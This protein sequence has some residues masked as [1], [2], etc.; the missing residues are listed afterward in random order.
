MSRKEIQDLADKIAT[1]NVEMKDGDLSDHEASTHL[2]WA[3]RK[4]DDL[5]DKLV[6]LT[7]GEACAQYTDPVL[8]DD[9]S[10]LTGKVSSGLTY[11]E[12]C[13]RVGS[14]AFGN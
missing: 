5:V 9:Y 6:V 12:L 10:A 1:L 11:N 14:Y 4:Y 2:R 3:L 7:K 8:C 13:E